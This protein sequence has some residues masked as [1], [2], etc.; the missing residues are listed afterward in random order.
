MISVVKLPFLL[1]FPFLLPVHILCSSNL[2]MFGENKIMPADLLYGVVAIS[3]QAPCKV[4]FV[5]SLR[6][7]KMSP[8]WTSSFYFQFLLNE[9]VS[10]YISQMKKAKT[11]TRQLYKI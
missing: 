10:L 1:D 7:I 9:D 2:L 4:L 6:E 8:S 5:E 3:L 11:H